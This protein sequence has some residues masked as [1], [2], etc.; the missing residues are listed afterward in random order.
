ML[1]SAHFEVLLYYTY[2]AHFKTK[3]YGFQITFQNSVSDNYEL[4]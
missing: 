1:I 4:L 2:K 3:K